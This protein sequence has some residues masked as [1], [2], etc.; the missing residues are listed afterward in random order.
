MNST[1]CNPEREPTPRVPVHWMLTGC[2]QKSLKIKAAVFPTQRANSFL[3]QTTNT[4]SALLARFWWVSVPSGLT[5]SFLAVVRTSTIWMTEGVNFRN[6]T[7][8]VQ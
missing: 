5:P 6:Q 2:A 7:L 8:L 1:E 4:C 3:K